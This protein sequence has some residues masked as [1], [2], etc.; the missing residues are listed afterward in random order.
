MKIIEVINSQEVIIEF[1]DFH[2]YVRHAYYH[3]FKKGAVQNPYDITVYDVGYLGVGRFNAGE[4]ATHSKAYRYW[5][6]LLER[7]YDEKFHEA[8]PM[9]KDCYVCEKWHCFQNF[10]EWFYKNYYEIGEGRMHLDKDIIF[11]GNKEYS[12]SKCIFVPQRINMI[13]MTRSKSNN[14]PTGIYKTKSTERYSVN[15][16]GSSYGTYNTL[17][18]AINIYNDQKRKHIKQVAFEYKD[19]IPDKVY[20]VLLGKSE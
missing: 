18:E 16:N 7:C 12:P 17:D 14:L 15:Y 19:K 20:Y 2:K 8:H 11:E 5:N 6:V 3:S 9:Y 4:N 13:F 10:A 1:Q